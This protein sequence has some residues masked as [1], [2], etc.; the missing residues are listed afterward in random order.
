ME[1]EFASLQLDNA[2]VLCVGG[3]TRAEAESAQ[4]EGMAVDGR[5]YYLFLADESAPREPVQVLARF[6]SAFEAEQ[7]SRLFARHGRLLSV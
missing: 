6:L 7:L 3:I 5:G 4:A 1:G 2:M